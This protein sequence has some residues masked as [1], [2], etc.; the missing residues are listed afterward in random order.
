MLSIEKYSIPARKRSVIVNSLTGAVS[1]GTLQ[2]FSPN[3]H[4]QILFRIERTVADGCDGAATI[5]DFF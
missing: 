3:D 1:A 2:L 4:A 5:T